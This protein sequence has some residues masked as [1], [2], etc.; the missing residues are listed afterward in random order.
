MAFMVAYLVSH[1]ECECSSH[2][3]I[4]PLCNE[5]FQSFDHCILKR[6][7]RSVVRNT[8]ISAFE[9]SLWHKLL[10]LFK[11]YHIKFIVYL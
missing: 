10:Q 3:N 9:L 4:Q 1:E 7:F 8:R 2:Y 11:T 5:N 6:I